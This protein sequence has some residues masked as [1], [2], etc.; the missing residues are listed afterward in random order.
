MRGWKA[1]EVNQTIGSLEQKPVVDVVSFAFV[2]F[3]SF[4]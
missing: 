1:E 2:S 4:V 3:A